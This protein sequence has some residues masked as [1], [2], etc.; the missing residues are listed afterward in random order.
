MNDDDDS[1]KMDILMIM[2]AIKVRQ[3]AFPADLR[4]GGTKPNSF[5]MVIAVITTLLYI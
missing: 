1:N 3:V 2:Y 4:V 5:R